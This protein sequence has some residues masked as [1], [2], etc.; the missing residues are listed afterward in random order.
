M[1]S[2]LMTG[3]NVEDYPSLKIF[4]LSNHSLTQI[5][6]LNPINPSFACHLHNLLFTLSEVDN[7]AQIQM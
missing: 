7:K 1:Y 4:S 2:L 5:T 3:Y 6:E